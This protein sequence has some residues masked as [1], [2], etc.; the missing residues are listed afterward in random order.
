MRDTMNTN[1]ASEPSRAEK[2][3]VELL[4]DCL[5]A[6]IYEESAWFVVE[7]SPLRSTKEI[8]WTPL[9]PIRRFVIRQLQKRRLLV[10]HVRPFDSATR[11]TGRDWPCFGY[12]MVGRAR[13]DN[14]EWCI[15]DVIERQ[16]PG[17]FVETGVWRGGSVIFMRAMLMF[18][19]I[20][21]RVVW[22]ADS[23]EGM[24]VPQDKSDGWD[25]SHV[26]KLRVSLEQVKQNFAR[27][28]L[29][30]KQVQFLKGWF[31]DTLPSA[32][33]QQLAILRLDGDLYHS[34]VD[35][36]TNL[37]HK[38][39]RGGYVIVDDYYSWSGCHRAVDEFLVCRGLRPD[40]RKIDSDSVYWQ[41]E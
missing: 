39:S 6:S 38:V 35:A 11:A 36:L 5:T 32:P 20:T 22:A 26:E 9:L 23:F 4:K 2:L 29:L 17:D 24:P 27:L 40:I 15:R 13:L 34:T 14:L 3:Y 7:P 33:I 31:S 1:A 12:T 30:D 16:I 41:V 10:V 28:G 19:G 8:G 18:R 21:D 25:R 37:Y